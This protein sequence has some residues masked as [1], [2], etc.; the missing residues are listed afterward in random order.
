[1]MNVLLNM[2]FL[3][4]LLKQLIIENRSP[5]I[6]N[7]DNQ[8]LPI[9]EYPHLIHLDVLSAH[10]DYIEQLLVNRNTCLS[11]Y[12]HLA[13]S[14]RSL[15]RVTHNFTRDT[16]RVNCAKVKYFYVCNESDLTEQFHVYFPHVENLQLLL[17]KIT[18]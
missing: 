15:Q 5:Q 14:Y 16:I 11:N 3:S 6:L 2:N 18:K 7:D 12:I 9:I 10:D 13:I 4:K 1:M 17:K 8:T